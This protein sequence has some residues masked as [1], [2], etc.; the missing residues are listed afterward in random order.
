MYRVGLQ[1]G[2][3]ETEAAKAGGKI[4]T[5]GSYKLGVHG[6]GKTSFL[7]FFFKWEEGGGVK[8]KKKVGI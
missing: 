5:F 4:F 3:S 6:T 8:Q 7:F 1:Q 2:L